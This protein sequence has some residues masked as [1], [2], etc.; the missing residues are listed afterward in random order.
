MGFR[1]L[2]T[3]GVTGSIPVPPTNIRFMR[4]AWKAWRALLVLDILGLLAVAVY[5]PFSW[6]ADGPSATPLL[7]AGLLSLCVLLLALLSSINA[8]L[9][10]RAGGMSW[11]IT[12]GAV[13]LALAGTVVLLLLAVWATDPSHATLRWMWLLLFVLAVLG[14]FALNHRAIGRCQAPS[15][16]PKSSNLPVSGSREGPHDD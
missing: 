6:P 3:A 9:W 8:A 12:L 15:P 1:R 11:G 16:R 10:A 4:T 2:H 13:V 14:A 5:V 7:M